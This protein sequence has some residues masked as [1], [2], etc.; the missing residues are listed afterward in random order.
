MVFVVSPAL[1]GP[2]SG[3]QNAAPLAIQKTPVSVEAE[4]GE[5]KP[6]I[7][8]KS[9]SFYGTASWYSKSNR[10]IR[11]RTANGD[12]F[13]DRKMTCASWDF[14]LGT[15]LKITNVRNGKS[16][17]CTVND[18]GPA[19]RLHRVVDLTKGAFR[20]IENV[21]KGLSKVLVTPVE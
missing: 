10:A 21:N 5:F 13:D 2:I 16:V 20:K 8:S 14:T 4:R 11:S 1:A 6:P 17:V 15:R 19:K 12:I 3:L 7:K 9:R 18:R